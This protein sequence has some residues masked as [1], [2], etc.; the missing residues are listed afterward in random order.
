MF[1]VEVVYEYCWWVWKL[2]IFVLRW[3]I[4]VFVVVISIIH[5][6]SLG[7]ERTYGARDAELS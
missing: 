5:R 2:W 1:W 7:D 4:I 6:S 3:F